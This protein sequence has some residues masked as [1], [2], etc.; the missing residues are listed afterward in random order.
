MKAKVMTIGPE[1]AK[2]MKDVFD[3]NGVEHRPI[4][5]G[6]LLRQPFLKDYKFGTPRKNANV[7]LLNDNGVY[8]GN[9][10]FVTD[11]DMDWLARTLGDINA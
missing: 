6:N 10:H 11:R 3:A 9:S 7:D 8:I 5:G 2:K 4:V 1:L